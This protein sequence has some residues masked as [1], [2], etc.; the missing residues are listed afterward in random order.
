MKVKQ[1]L[2]GFYDAV[3][4]VDHVHF[5][6][7]FTVLLVLFIGTLLASTPQYRDESQ[8]F[9]LVIGIPT[10]L[11]LVFLLAVQVSP[12]L[13]QTIDRYATSDLFDLDDVVSDMDRSVAGGGATQRSLPEERESVASISLWTL[14]LFGIILLVGFLPGTLIFL[15]TFYRFHAG[16]NPVRTLIYSGVMWAFIVVI[17][18]IVLNT[19]FYTGVLGVELPLPF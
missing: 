5:D 10:F 11:L 8:L 6:R 9:P 1:R 16:Q 17:F 19:P 4:D 2:L 18:E 7:A 14:A 15:L 3:L 12:R 13:N